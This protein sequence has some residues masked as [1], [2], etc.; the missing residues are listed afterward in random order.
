MQASIAAVMCG[1]SCVLDPASRG[2]LVD[3]LRAMHSPIR[4]RGPDGEGFAYVSREGGFS[5]H[6]SGDAI[7]ALAFR[8]LKIQDTLDE[9][10]QPFASHD[11]SVRLLFNGEIYNFRALR[12][13]LEREGLAFHTESDTE[14]VAAAYDRWG[15]GCFARFRGMWAMVIV[16]LRTRHVVVSRDRFGI[17]PLQ[18]FSADGRLYFA[19]EAKQLL[20]VRS[21]RAD[22]DA[23]LHFLTGSRIPDRERTFLA[24]VRS[25][26][27]GTFATIPLDAGPRELKFASYWTLP[28]N[29]TP[30]GFDVALDQLRELMN[31]VVGLHMTAAVPVG[32]LLSGGID[33]SVVA[34]IARR[35]GHSFPTF[36]MF[37]EPSYGRLDESPFIL[38]TSKRLEIANHAVTVTATDVREHFDRVVA[39]H[40][41]P[42]AGIALI[43]QYLVYKLAAEHGV[44]VVL[45]GQGADEEFAGYPRQQYA[46][47]LDLLLR[48]RWLRGGR[49][50]AALGRHDS[51]EWNRFARNAAGTLLRPLRSS[52]AAHRLAWLNLPAREVA[53]FH[54]GDL[55]TAKHAPGKTRLARALYADT[56]SLNLYDVL[57]IGDRNAMAHSIESRVPFVD[58]VLTEF[59]FTLPD[60]LKIGDGWRK[61]LLR[62]LAAES[63]PSEVAYR[64]DKMGFAVPQA[65]WMRSHFADEI[66]GLADRDA[67]AASTLF[68]RRGVR[69]LTE[70]FLERGDD[71]AASSVWR[72]LAAARWSEVHG[73]TID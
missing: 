56:M 23:L 2:T 73:V 10:Q 18:Y 5:D 53:R 17:K 4:H 40:E 51:R 26:P 46:Y 66:R 3:E 16:D 52:R 71:T 25:V 24:G 21:A 22:H 20:A 8:W 61:H 67:I 59:A 43:A 6:P 60:E 70:Q 13:E 29:V 69:D 49:E 33:S 11:G 47:L 9:A 58:H 1:I 41:E 42:L 57:G 19:S 15:T 28:T 45:D 44:R 63:I 7:A 50:L 34:A 35:S 55:E 31:E 68:E 30:V 37:L 64:T 54:A 27:P 65:R 39:T 36:S 14:V 38:A 72:I 32:A 62:R 12:A 48:L